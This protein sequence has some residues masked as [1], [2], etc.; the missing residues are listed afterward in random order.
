MA[1]GLA[2][3]WLSERQGVGV[4]DLE[5]L[6]YKVQS[7]GENNSTYIKRLDDIAATKL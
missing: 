6:G 3:K 2:K 4:Q 7:R 5:E 1:E